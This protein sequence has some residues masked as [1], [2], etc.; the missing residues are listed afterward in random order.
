MDKET[1]LAYLKSILASSHDIVNVL[2]TIASQFKSME[3]ASKG[4]DIEFAMTF[5]D[6]VT[7]FDNWSTVFSLA[8]KP[9]SDDISILTVPSK[10]EA[11]K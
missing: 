3:K 9:A 8:S 7:V 2:E 11:T 6:M 4:T 1:E 5:L 10:E